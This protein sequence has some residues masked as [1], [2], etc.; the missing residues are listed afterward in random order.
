MDKKLFKEALGN[1]EMTDEEMYSSLAA[2]GLDEASI[3]TLSQATQLSSS[4]LE[5]LQTALAAYNPSQPRDGRGRWGG[6][7]GGGGGSSGSESPSGGGGGDFSKLSDNDL[8]LKLL[9]IRADEAVA[10]ALGDYAKAEKLRDQF[11][12]GLKEYDKRTKGGFDPNYNPF[13]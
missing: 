8:H 7:G 9:D 1:K 2:K 10:S 5:L 13:S 6:G 4:R 3:A 11:E 12:K